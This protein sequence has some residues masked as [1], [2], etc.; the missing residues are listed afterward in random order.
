M[1]KSKHD[2]AMCQIFLKRGGNKKWPAR[3]LLHLDR[4]LEDIDTIVQ[5]CKEL[6]HAAP[7]DFDASPDFPLNLSCEHRT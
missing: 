4:S 5:H 2:C 6:A 7:E 3:A 1:A